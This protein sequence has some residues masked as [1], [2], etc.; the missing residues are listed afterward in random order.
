MVKI[1]ELTNKQL[2]ESIDKYHKTLEQLY[3][4]RDRRLAEGES[5]S[6]LYTPDELK[7]RALERKKEE[8]QFSLSLA[9]EDIEAIEKVQD[10]NKPDDEEDDE[11]VRVTTLLRLSKDQLAELN[12]AKQ[13]QQNKG[14]KPAT[15]SKGQ[16]VQSLSISKGRIKIKK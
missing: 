7:K 12:K 4:D 15:I 2:V 10:Q 8:D 14:Q 1:V 3:K 5:E 11:L 6:E 13:E 9:D 16:K